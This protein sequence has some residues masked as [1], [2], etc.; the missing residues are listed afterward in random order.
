MPGT[1]KAVN[2]DG[3]E[4]EFDEAT[5]IYRSLVGGR[6]IVY[7]SGTTFINKFF[8]AFDPD[9]VIAARKARQMG[10]TPEEVKAQWKAKADAACEL[11]TRVHETCEDVLHGAAER[12]N[13]P[14]NDHERHLM[15]AGIAAA[16]VVKERLEVVGIERVV[17]NIPIRIAGTIDL[18]CRSK[19]NRNLWWILDWKTNARIDFDSR[20]NNY[21][22][23]PINHLYDCSGVHYAL[24]LSL[25]EFLL[26]AGA[27][28]P[29]EAEV[30]RGIYHLTDAGP[31]FY[32]LPNY[33]VEVR[34]M[35]INYL[36]KGGAA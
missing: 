23:A 14:Q 26:R 8:R 32:E 12:R 22:I 33:G 20:F 31:H 17:F 1:S 15:D 30:R 11:G 25:Y 5:H 35:I 2:P 16:R 6:E 29:H 27:Y 34:D 24:Q 10:V 28:I 19:S 3:V 21:G 9:G 36:A 18:L 4:I 7:T 13:K